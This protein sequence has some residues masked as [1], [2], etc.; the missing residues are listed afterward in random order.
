MTVS[1]DLMQNLL[2]MAGGRGGAVLAVEVQQV[3]LPTG[4]ARRKKLDGEFKVLFCF[5]IIKRGCYF[6]TPLAILSLLTLILSA[7]ID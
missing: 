5:H 2:L 6:D 3:S 4:T 7:K 1:K